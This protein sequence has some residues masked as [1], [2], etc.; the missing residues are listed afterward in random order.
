MEKVISII[1]EK[2]AGEYRVILTPREVKLF[3]DKGF[4]VLVEYGAGE[5]IGISDISFEE[6]GAYL[7]D[8]ETAWNSSKLILKYKPPTDE[9]I[10]YLDETKVLGAVYHAEGNLPLVSKLMNSGVTAF[11]YEFF[12]TK[13]GIFPLSV[14]SS[15]IAGKVAVIYGAYHLQRQLGGEGVLLAPV[16]NVRGP[17]VLIIGYGNAGSAA[18]RLAVAMGGQ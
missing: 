3:V 9:E 11:T 10:E 6:A 2:R 4:K 5:N 17:K 13:E 7:V 8:T 14:A 16:V 1:K 15:E 18:A 12:R